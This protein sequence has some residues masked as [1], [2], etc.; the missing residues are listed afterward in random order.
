MTNP[1]LQ[2][3]IDGLEAA[4][5]LREESRISF[6]TPYPKQQEFFYAGAWARERLLLAGNQ[7]GKSEGGAVEVVY[8]LTGEYPDDWL[9]RR[10]DHPVTAW[11]AGESGLAVRDTIQKKLCGEPGIEGSLGTGLIPKAA[12]VGKPSLSRGVADAYDTIYIRHKSGGISTLGFKSYEQGRGKFQGATLDFVWMDEECPMEIYSE[13]LTRTSATGGFVFT[14]FT[15]LK[16]KTQVVCRFLEEKST[17]RFGVTMTV[18]DVPLSHFLIKGEALGSVTDEELLKRRTAIIAGYPSHERDA[19]TK[20]TPLLGSGRIFTL[21][22][23]AISEPAIRDV[24]PHW[25]KLWGTDFGIDHPFAAVLILWDKDLDVV[26]VHACLKI[27][28]QL[29]LQHAAAMKPIGIAVP[30]A[31][32]HDGNNR[33]K[34]GGETVA[35]AYRKQ[36]LSMLHEHA[37]FAEGGYSTEA[38][39]MEM[40]SRLAEGKLKVASHLSQW[41]EEY[42]QYHRKD[43]LIVK[44][45]DDLMSATRIAIMAKRFARAVPLGGKKPARGPE[46]Q[47]ASGVHLSAADLWG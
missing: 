31:W 28:D 7:L 19:R 2:E 39:V 18:Y 25:V 42:R 12:F 40:Q 6:F 13:C 47:M 27:S 9:G 34:I 22:E 29:P 26:H 24:P 33:E 43:G 16:G 30:V 4:V 1:A 36:G 41:F 21:A 10:F 37:T 11:A 8:H 35:S 46:T 17:D 32:P 23:E 5:R 14:T 38:G 3:I 15:P 44:V 20:G 45:N